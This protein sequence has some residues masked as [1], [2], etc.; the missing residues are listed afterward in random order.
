V[1]NFAQGASG[2]VLGQG[3]R[4]NIVLPNST[5]ILSVYPLPD[6]EQ[7]KQ[8]NSTASTELSWYA[9]EPLYDFNLA[10]QVKT[11]ATDEVLQFFAS[12]YSDLGTLIYVIIGGAAL[13]FIV[14]TYFKAGR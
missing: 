12:I 6:H 7:A 1:L 14:Y 4:F 2:V 3:M 13:L 11:S 10:F 5:T 8:I 9:S